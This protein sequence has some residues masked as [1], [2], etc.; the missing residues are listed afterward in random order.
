MIAEQPVLFTE[1]FEIPNYTVGAVIGR[2]GEVI[3][4]LQD[5][6]G[7][8]ISVARINGSTATSYMNPVTLKGS[9]DQIMKA[10]RK[11]DDIVNKNGGYPST[12]SV[13]TSSTTCSTTL[14]ER[15][16]GMAKK[17]VDCERKEAWDVVNKRMTGDVVDK[18][19]YGNQDVVVDKS[20][21]KNEK[22]VRV[23]EYIY[24]SSLFICICLKEKS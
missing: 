18:E 22:E 16:E 8:R 20:A 10:R 11:I 3:R 15:S 7:C 14:N 13:S 4:S 2:N 21:A 9:T 1:D 24:P 6:T 23:V 5:S 12:S 17:T 19:F